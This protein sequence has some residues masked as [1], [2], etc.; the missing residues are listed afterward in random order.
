MYMPS[1]FGEDLMDDFFNDNWFRSPAFTNNNGMMR[2][3]VK[4]KD[5]NYELEMELPG[6]KKDDVQLSLENGY[7]NIRAAHNDNKDEKDKDG[8]IV[9]KERYTGA[10]ERSFYVGDNIT[11]DDVHAKFEDGMLL[12]TLPDPEQKKPI[13]NKK[14]IM[15]EG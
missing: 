1:I 11:E 13:E 8:K 4:Q 7:L 2:T 15:I 5:G 3:D 10:V 9:R 12:I 6:F 14:T